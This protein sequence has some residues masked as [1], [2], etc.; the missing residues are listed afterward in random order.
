MKTLIKSITN[1][2]IM[3]DGFSYDRSM[4]RAHHVWTRTMLSAVVSAGVA[5]VGTYLGYQA[6]SAPFASAISND[7]LNFKLAAGAVITSS[8]AYTL[9]DLFRSIT[10]DV[11]TQLRVARANSWLVKGTASNHDYSA[12]I[13]MQE[14]QL[15]MVRYVEVEGGIKVFAI[16]KHPIYP[17]PIL[18]EAMLFDGEYPALAIFYTHAADIRSTLNE[19]CAEWSGTVA[20]QLGILLSSHPAPAA[21]SEVAMKQPATEELEEELDATMF[22]DD[23]GIDPHPAFSRASA[24]RIR[25]GE[26]L[27]RVA[28]IPPEAITH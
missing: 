9:R 11:K 13:A 6:L 22:E 21:G 4:F 18:L 7:P 17:E 3:L 14:T 15:T 10:T 8:L 5:A 26:A 23:M 16:A 20:D 1:D 27:H 28:Q 24:P 2:S 12:H 25:P 19:A